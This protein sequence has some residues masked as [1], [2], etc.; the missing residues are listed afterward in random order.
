MNDV[1]VL[2]SINAMEYLLE[3][4]EHTLEIEVAVLKLVPKIFVAM[5]EDDKTFVE[6][7]EDI[8]DLDN[9]RRGKLCQA[10]NFIRLQLFN[11]FGSY[12]LTGSFQFA[13]PHL[14]ISPT[15]QQ[16]F[17]NHYSLSLEIDVTL[18]FVLQL[19]CLALI[20]LLNDWRGIIFLIVI[21]TKLS[22]ILI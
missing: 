3:V 14:R 15:S 22:Q 21:A 5:L 8:N 1:P 6:V 2:K 7:S 9:V 4:F 10:F 13:L 12:F 16:P 11:L 18:L 20:L 17:V 19:K